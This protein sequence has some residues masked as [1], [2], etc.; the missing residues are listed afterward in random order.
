MDW[1]LEQF[2]QHIS[3]AAYAESLGY[4]LDQRESSKNSWVMRS[5]DDKV[6]IATN[7]N[8]HG[9]Y[10]SVYDEQ[11][12]GTIIDF[13]Q[14]RVSQNLGQVRK[15]LRKW[16]SIS[17]SYSPRQHEA[18]SRFRRPEAANRSLLNT[19]KPS[20]FRLKTT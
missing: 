18:I 11:D 10:F 20:Q 6:V 19:A 16:L 13:V 8:G 15:E 9:I 5:L 1:E 12:N 2:K 14:K 7:Q 3:L 17:F 4:Q